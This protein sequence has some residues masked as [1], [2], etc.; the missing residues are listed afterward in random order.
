MPAGPQ[1]SSLQVS[2]NIIRLVFDFNQDISLQSRH[3]RDYTWTLTTA[4]E[5]NVTEQIVHCRC[6]RNSVTY[7][8]KR[9]AIGDGS[10]GFRYLFAC[11]PLTVSLQKGYFST[12]ALLTYIYFSFNSNSAFAVSASSL[13][14]CLRSGN[15]RSSWTRS[16]ST[17]CASAPKDTAVPATI[18]SPACWPARASWR[19]TYRRTPATAW[20]TIEEVLRQGTLLDHS[21]PTHTHCKG[22]K[23]RSGAGSSYYIDISTEPIESRQVNNLNKKKKEK[24]KEEKHNEHLKNRSQELKCTSTE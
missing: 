21:T 10:Q 5:L 12:K 16:T 4:A 9:E 19:T 8:T 17:H 11:S 13:A 7:L 14:N 18:P 6:P 1:A 3:F 24:R 22:G 2:Y 15:A 20:P 23:R